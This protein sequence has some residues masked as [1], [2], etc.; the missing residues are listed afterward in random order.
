MSW[1]CEVGERVASAPAGDRDT[2]RAGFLIFSANT[3]SVARDR[4]SL[5]VDG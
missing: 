4:L 3:L 5:L 1:L 2:S